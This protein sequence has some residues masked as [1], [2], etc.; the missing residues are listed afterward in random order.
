MYIYIYIY[1]YI[2]IYIYIYNKANDGEK[3]N[4]FY[5]KFKIFVLIIYKINKYLKSV[6][7]LNAFQDFFSSVK[8][9]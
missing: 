7:T 3:V 9:L 4:L 1:I 5:I 6:F 2:H 8:F